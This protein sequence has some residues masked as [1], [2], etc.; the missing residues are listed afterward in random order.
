MSV[1][2]IYRKRGEA[3]IDRH[4]YRVTVVLDGDPYWDEGIRFYHSKGRRGNKRQIFN[5][6]YRMYRTWKHNRKYQWK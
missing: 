5:H 3:I 2:N 6:Q 1:N 4:T